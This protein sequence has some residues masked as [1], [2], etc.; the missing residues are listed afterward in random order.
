[1]TT[2]MQYTAISM[3]VKHDH[4]SIKVCNIFSNFCLNMIKAALMSTQAM[5]KIRNI[6]DSE[7][8]MRT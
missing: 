6:V 1:M 8:L 4:F 7:M 5:C 3:A 2:P